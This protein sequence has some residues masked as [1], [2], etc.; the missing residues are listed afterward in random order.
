MSSLVCIVSQKKEICYAVVIDNHCSPIVCCSPYAYM[1]PLSA[2]LT[3]M[4]SSLLKDAL[5][6]YTYDAHLAGLGY[7]IH[8][9]I[10]GLVVCESQF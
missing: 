6:E 4:F 3:F 9:S 10:Y 5:T 8:S 7:D 1:D 2:N